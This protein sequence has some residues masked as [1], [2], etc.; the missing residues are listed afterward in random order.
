MSNIE[1]LKTGTCECTTAPMGDNGLE[2]FT[3]A[4]TYKFEYVKSFINKPY[5][6][7]YLNDD[8]YETCSKI[9]F[10]KYFKIKD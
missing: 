1:I 2:G 8:Y 4:L 10:N 6:R 9:T 3:Y 7:I 5:Y